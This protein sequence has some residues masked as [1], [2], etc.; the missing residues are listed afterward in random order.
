[1]AEVE[2]M[3]ARGDIDWEPYFE[4]QDARH[5]IADKAAARVAA[6][7]LSPHTTG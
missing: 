4:E 2:E 5:A 6:S 7:P 1:M 3:A